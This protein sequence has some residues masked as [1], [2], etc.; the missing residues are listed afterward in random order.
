MQ[1]QETVRLQASEAAIT[2]AV[3]VAEILRMQNSAITTKITT[4]YALNRPK[5]RGGY[6][7]PK[8]EL[9][10]QRVVHSA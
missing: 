6:R 3:Q 5:D 10:L 2:A 9:M 4:R 7:V 8:I 1:K